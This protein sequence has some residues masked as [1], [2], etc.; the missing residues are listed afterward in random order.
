MKKLFYLLLFVLILVSSCKKQITYKQVNVI[1]EYAEIQSKEDISTFTDTCITPYIYTKVISLRKLPVKE[2]KQKFVEMLLPSILLIQ[3]NLNQKIKRLEHIELWLSKK[4]NYIKSDSIFLF[5]LF[6]QY[7]CS[8]IEELKIRLKPH[9]ASIVLG[10]A[11]IESGWGSS[12]FFQEGNNVFGIWSYNAGENRIKALVGRDSTNIY[13]RKYASIEASVK[14]YY[15]TIARLNA[16]KEFRNNRSKTT[17]PYKLV[18]L[19]YRYSEVGDV[20]TD[21]LHK[22]IKDND[23]TKFDSYTISKKY[24]KEETVDLSLLIKYPLNSIY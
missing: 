24:L 3:H 15:K 16:Y 12:R 23:L 6:K 20:Y 1:P 21:Y 4:Q 13:V 5:D 14:D 22:I 18:P 8:E 19:L 10:Q 9:S 2:K 11:A 7:N 17:D